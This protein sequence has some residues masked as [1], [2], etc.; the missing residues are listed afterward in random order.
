MKGTEVAKELQKEILA[1][2]S[3]RPSRL[4]VGVLKG[5]VFKNKDG[6]TFTFDDVEH[7]LIKCS[8]ILIGVLIKDPI[9]NIYL[10]TDER[11]AKP[12]KMHADLVL[13]SGKCLDF[14]K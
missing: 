1:S 3:E 6:E 7:L 12:C 5:R 4:E 13:T 8:L 2:L 11:V 10:V 9:F 14:N